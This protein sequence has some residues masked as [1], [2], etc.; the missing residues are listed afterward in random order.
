[1]LFFLSDESERL[2][3]PRNAEH[4][5]RIASVFKASS[6]PLAFRGVPLFWFSS[7]FFFLELF[8]LSVQF[9]SDSAF[10]LFHIVPVGDHE[11]KSPVK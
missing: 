6:V 11:F 10:K 3:T 4:Q 9:F 7:D 1:M 2:R 8:K 5:Y